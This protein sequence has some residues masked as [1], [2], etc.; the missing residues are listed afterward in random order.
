MNVLVTGSNGFIGSHVCDYLKKKNIYVIGLGRNDYSRANTDEYYSFDMSSEDVAQVFEEEKIDAVIHLAADMRQE[1]Y[2]TEV[3]FHN[4]VGTERIL[5]LC[6]KYN[7]GVFT[8]L[9]SLPVIGS[10]VEHPITEQHPLRPYTVYHCTKVM[11]ELLAEYAT[12]KFGLRTS[13]FRISAPVGI[14][15]NPKTIFSV[16]VENA[17]C[18]K[19]LILAGKGGRKQTYIHVD[20]ISQALYLAIINDNAQGVYNLSSYN[21]LS[22]KELAERIIQLTCSKSDIKFNGTEDKEENR[23]WD[24]SIDKIKKE[25]G[26]EPLVSIDEAIIELAEYYRNHDKEL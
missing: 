10:P 19:P 15:M 2:T 1:P 4:C 3:I 14:G 24:V 9:S 13:S 5:K 21:L 25:I 18:N 20:D 17:V 23:V 12:D 8:E 11:E 22:N 6:T 26:Y 16:F 7:V